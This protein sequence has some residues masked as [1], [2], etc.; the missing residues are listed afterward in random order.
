MSVVIRDIILMHIWFSV[1]CS[2]SLHVVACDSVL[3]IFYCPFGFLE[4]LLFLHKHLQC[5]SKTI[6][7]RETSTECLQLLD[8]KSIG[9]NWSG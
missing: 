5:S 1:L 7:Y 9:R 2:L 8:C 4:R 3:S 6:N